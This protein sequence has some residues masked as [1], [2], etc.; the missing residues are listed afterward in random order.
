MTSRCCRLIHSHGYDEELQRLRKL[1][2]TGRAS[3]AA[4][5]GR[6]LTDTNRRISQPDG[7]ILVCE[8]N[9]V[10]GAAYCWGWQFPRDSPVALM[11]ENAYSSA[12]ITASP[13]SRR[14]SPKATSSSLGRRA[15]G[16]SRS[17]CTGPRG[18]ARA[19]PAA[20]EAGGEG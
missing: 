5:V 19:V 11:G 6:F 1:T 18:A 9:G 8:Y 3:C 14:T 12:P 17:C 16:R 10:E 15:A 2:H 13:A 20:G 7:I 4:I